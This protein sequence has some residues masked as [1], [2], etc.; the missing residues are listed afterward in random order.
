MHL[1][2]GGEAGALAVE[3]VP[4]VSGLSARVMDLTLPSPFAHFLNFTAARLRENVGEAPASRS[5]ALAIASP[6]AAALLLLM[7]L[8]EYI[9]A[10]MS[11]RFAAITMG[12]AAR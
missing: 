5:T 6:H 2:N 1:P 9:P 12:H 10:F 11:D 3:V 4:G 7:R 8:V